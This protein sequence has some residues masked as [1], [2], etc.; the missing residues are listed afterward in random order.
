MEQDFDDSDLRMKLYICSYHSLCLN[1]HL[2]DN[3]ELSQV[4]IFQSDYLHI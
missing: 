2:A 1:S 3:Y 4:K